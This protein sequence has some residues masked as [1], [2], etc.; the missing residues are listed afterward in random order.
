[1]FLGH[2]PISQSFSQSSGSATAVS[3]RI[4]CRACKNKFQS[5]TPRVS[6]LE[7]LWWG[8]GIR[9]SN[10]VPD[11]ADAAVSCFYFSLFR[12][13]YLLFSGCSGSSLLHLDFLYSC[14]EWGL[15]FIAVSA[16]LTALASC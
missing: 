11:A 4:T 15:L 16:V 12:F 2:L 3:I 14:G 6:G 10:K 1:M 7:G 9:L 13:I 8:L 5:P